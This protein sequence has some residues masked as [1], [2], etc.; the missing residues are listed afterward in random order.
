MG[1]LLGLLIM[2]AIPVLMILRGKWEDKR[3]PEHFDFDPP[4]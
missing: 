1:G 3:P 4:E 2:F